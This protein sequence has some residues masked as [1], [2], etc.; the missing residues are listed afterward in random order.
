[1]IL[2]QEFLQ[3]SAFGRRNAARLLMDSVDN[4]GPV[5][6]ASECLENTRPFEGHLVLS[7]FQITPVIF[8]RHVNAQ[9]DAAALERRFKESIDVIGDNDRQMPFPGKGGKRPVVHVGPY[10]A[11]IFWHRGIHDIK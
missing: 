2:F 10:H 1:M 5:I 4:R 8:V 7:S 11:K 6:D 3:D 9:R